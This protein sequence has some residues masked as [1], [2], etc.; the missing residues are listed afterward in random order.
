[1]RF[2]LLAG[3]HIQ[4]VPNPEY[5]PN[6]PESPKMIQKTFQAKTADDIVE[7]DVNLAE[8]YGR[9]KFVQI[10]DRRRNTVTTEPV[11]SSSNQPF[12]INENNED[13]DENEE[14][15]E[16]STQLDSMTVAQLR[17]V[18]TEYKVDLTGISRKE[19]IIK[20]IRSRKKV[21]ES[22]DNDD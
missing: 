13:E 6:D 22:E 21:D 18:A 20:A 4:K 9:E 8:K 14:F 10:S 1:M 7:S 5:D 17:E 3:Q 19:D 2:K 15:N 12:N 11:R 16:L